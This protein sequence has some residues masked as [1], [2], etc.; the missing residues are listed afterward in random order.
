[1]KHMLLSSHP[2]VALRVAAVVG[3]A[4]ASFSA[5]WALGGSW[6]LETV[7]Q[8]A[9]DLQAK[10]PVMAGAVLLAVAA[11]K[12]ALAV[13]PVAECSTDRLQRTRWRVPLWLAAVG[14]FVYGTVYSVTGILVVTGIVDPV[15]GYDQAGMIGHAFIWDPLFALWGFS[16]GAG[17]LALRR[18]SVALLPAQP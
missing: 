14:L 10:E 4:H 6:L 2:P 12:V 3:L 17:L 15:G 13:F 7:G 8:R 18:R 5:Y 1:M 9:V 16:L 11:G